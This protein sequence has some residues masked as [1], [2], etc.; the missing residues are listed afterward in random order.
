MRH[1]PAPGRQI[2]SGGRVGRANRDDGP[3]RQRVDGLAEEHEQPVADAEGAAVDAGRGFGEVGDH[4]APL[5]EQP[6]PLRGV[7]EHLIALH[8][9]RVGAAASVSGLRGP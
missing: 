4:A 3:G 8:R 1:D 9:L 5:L 6:L 2:V 7:E